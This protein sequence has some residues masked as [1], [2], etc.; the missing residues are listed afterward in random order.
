MAYYFLSCTKLNYL[1]CIK[2]G[3]WGAKINKIKKWESGDK[4]LLC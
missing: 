3:M 4:L 2:S 1:I